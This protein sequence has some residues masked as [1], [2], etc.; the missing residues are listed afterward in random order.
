M[1][2]KS[3]VFYK[4]CSEAENIV[5]TDREFRLAVTKKLRQFRNKICEQ[6]DFLKRQIKKRTRQI[7]ELKNSVN[8]L[9]CTGQPTWKTEV[10]WQVGIWK[11]RKKNKLKNSKESLHEL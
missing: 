3:T 1:K 8:E 2:R 10:T 9:D 5:I 7:L 11:Y 6:N 4:S